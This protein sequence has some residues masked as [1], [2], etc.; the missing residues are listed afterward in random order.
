[1]TTLS[2]NIFCIMFKIMA[3]FIITLFANLYVRVAGADPWFQVR[4]DALKIIERSEARKMLGYFVW[5][6]TILRK[7]IILFPILGGRRVRPPW[8]VILLTCGMHLLDCIISL[9]G[10]VWFKHYRLTHLF[11]MY[12]CAGV[13]ILPMSTILIFDFG[14]VPTLQ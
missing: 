13:S 7:K 3:F 10:D 6:I 14:I 9:R 5:K 11:F 8:I 4:G 2:L 1:M 12:F